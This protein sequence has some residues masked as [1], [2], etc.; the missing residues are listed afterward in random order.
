MNAVAHSVDSDIFD[1]EIHLSACSKAYI[2]C[3]LYQF[4]KVMSNRIVSV[5]LKTWSRMHPLHV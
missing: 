2:Q 1:V 5:Q 4:L 3:Y